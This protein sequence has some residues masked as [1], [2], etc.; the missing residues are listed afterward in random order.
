MT[1]EA[2]V[3]NLIR[4]FVTKLCSDDSTFQKQIQDITNRKWKKLQMNET[5]TETG[6]ILE[7]LLR[8]L[9]REEPGK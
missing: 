3:L 9:S 8:E 6:R 1:I 2:K 5:E 4:G 7:T